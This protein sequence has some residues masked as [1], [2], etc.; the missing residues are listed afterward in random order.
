MAERWYLS[1]KM[2]GLPDFNFPAFNRWAARLR[3]EGFDV[4]NPAELDAQDTGPM[5]WADYLRRDIPQ[6]LTC[7][8]IAMIPGWETSKGA[9]L[10]KH[11]AQELGMRVVYLTE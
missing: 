7:N 9:R 4:L 6:L 1:G 2:S 8:A 5:E 3:A 10:E 11:I